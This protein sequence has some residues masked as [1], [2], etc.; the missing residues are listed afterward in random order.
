ML[1]LRVERTGVA[2]VVKGVA[3]LCSHRGWSFQQGGTD[4]DQE[5]LVSMHW[6]C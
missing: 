3:G 5:C 4:S 1:P 6:Q 2:V